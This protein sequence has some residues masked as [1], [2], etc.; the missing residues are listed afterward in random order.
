MHAGHVETPPM[1]TPEK[2]GYE[3]AP[4]ETRDVQDVQEGDTKSQ[5]AIVKCHISHSQEG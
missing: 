1:V 3:G 2:I 4:T 5:C